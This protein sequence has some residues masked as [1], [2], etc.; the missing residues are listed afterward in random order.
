MN[1][2]CDQKFIEK[3]NPAIYERTNGEQTIIVLLN[4][5]DRDVRRTV[6]FS[7]VIKAQNTIITGNE[8]VLKGQSFA[9][10]LK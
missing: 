3:G 9:I 1:V 2:S 5:A 8:I 10:L 7:K 4:P 6:E